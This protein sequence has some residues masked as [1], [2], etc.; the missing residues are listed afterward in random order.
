MYGA[1][2]LGNYIKICGVPGNR[3]HK[4]QLLQW[5]TVLILHSLFFP[6][7][8]FMI[9]ALRHDVLIAKKAYLQEASNA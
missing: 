3:I 9:K 6:A 2:L 4:A 1:K 8:L 5:N 7:P